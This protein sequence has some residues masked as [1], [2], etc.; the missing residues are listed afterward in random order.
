MLRQKPANAFGVA[1][2][3]FAQPPADRLL[4][5][6]LAILGETRGPPKHPL[7]VALLLGPR[8]GEDQRRPPRPQMRVFDPGFD[9]VEPA[10]VGD[11]A[12]RPDARQI[13][14]DRPAVEIGQ[15]LGHETPDLGVGLDSLAR[16]D[17]SGDDLQVPHRLAPEAR[18]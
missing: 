13:V 5:E 9:P 18:A 12:A 15:T 17:P 2:R 8:Q 10:R 16:Q 14:R 1:L 11:E 6:P 7:G 3:Q 4:D